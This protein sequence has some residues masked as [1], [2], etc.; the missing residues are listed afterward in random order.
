VL[1]AVTA[2]A[3]VVIVLFTRVYNV[4]RVRRV[5]GT[6]AVRRAGASGIIAGAE[7]FRLAGESSREVLLL[8][9]FNDTP[10]SVARFAR[11]LGGHGFSVT[12]PLL[13]GHGRAAESMP[14][15]DTANAW[16]AHARSSWE[17]IRARSP[18][19][20][21]AGQS[22]GGAIA[23]ILAED[24][25]PAAMVLLAPYVEMGWMARVL[26]RIW[27]LTSIV[28]PRLLSDP[29]RGL[30]DAGARAA[31]LGGGYFTPRRLNELREVTARAQDAAAR[32]QCPV[33]M[34]QGR[35]DYRIP[36]RS[37]Q[38]TFDRLGSRDKELVW[39]D[40]VGHVIAADSAPVDIAALTARWLDE[41]VP[42]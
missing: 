4:K 27:P 14:E 24:A 34:L 36:S 17:E 11:A 32:T 25:P 40:N 20:V 30:R 18:R 8:H 26:A 10:Q 2:V 33:L 1:V 22:M 16:I 42:R 12:V 29:N 28:L 6:R 7:P 5:L 19:A 37:A 31:T 21:L 3:A 38:R 9:G 39:I 35:T 13:P 23:I 41:R 15:T